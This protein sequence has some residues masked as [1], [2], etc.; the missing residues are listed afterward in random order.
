MAIT[1]RPC[2]PRRPWPGRPRGAGRLLAR[3]SR[4][5]ASWVKGLYLYTLGWLTWVVN[6][7]N[8]HAYRIFM[9]IHIVLQ[10]IY[11]VSYSHAWFGIGGGCLGSLLKE[12]G[13]DLP[14]SS[15]A[16]RNAS[17]PT[18]ARVGKGGY[19]MDPEGLNK[20]FWAFIFRE[21][22]SGVGRAPCM[23]NRPAR[24]R[25]DLAQESGFSGEGR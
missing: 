21:R 9:N 14:A 10:C 18:R 20:L 8:S 25:H 7:I 16:S 2:W 3:P 15:A 24:S 12:P 5:R 13:S 23:T 6:V 19:V 1:H 22:S 4:P 17:T 11:T